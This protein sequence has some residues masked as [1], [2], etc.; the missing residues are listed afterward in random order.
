MA[1][2]EAPCHD[3]LWPMP[4]LHLDSNDGG[5]LT[6][7]PDGRPEPFYW[8]VTFQAADLTAT[9]DVDLDA[10]RHTT[11]P[12]GEYFAALARDWRGWADARTWGRRPLALSATHDGLGHVTLTV[13]LTQSLYPGAWSVR[14]P[15]QL[16]AGGLDDVA[17]QAAL[18]II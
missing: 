8:H 12:I 11:P 7:E 15:I 6:I 9:A 5:A 13:E 10:L 3:T 14:I 16:D 4:T 18:L 1:S 17:R 2:Q